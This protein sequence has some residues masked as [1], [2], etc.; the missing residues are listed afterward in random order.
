M[1]LV[2]SRIFAGRRS[3][4]HTG[5]GVVGMDNAKSEFENQ[6]RRFIIK[7]GLHGNLID[8]GYVETSL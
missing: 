8:L 2:P 6:F 3:L 4:S 1:R 7:I 5:Y